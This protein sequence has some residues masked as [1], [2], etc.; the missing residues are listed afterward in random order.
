[1]LEP[2][3]ARLVPPPAEG[4]GLRRPVRAPTTATSWSASTARPRASTCKQ[5][6]ILSVGAIK[7]KGDTILTSQRLDFLVRPEGAGARTR[8]ILIHHIRPVD[9]EDAVPV[10]EA[11]R[12][13]LDFIGP[14][15]LIGYFLEFDIAMLNKY[16]RPLIGAAAAQP[17]DRGLAAL[18]RLA[19]ARR[20]RRAATSTCASRPSASGSTCRAAPRT[21][22]S[23]MRC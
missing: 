20:S 22:L 17:P 1:M 10:D 5:D 13:V 4:P 8:T 2:L 14:R 19:C 9:L 23:T 7:V 18:L 6:Q 16:V 11:M 3:E 15:P 12:R 21:T